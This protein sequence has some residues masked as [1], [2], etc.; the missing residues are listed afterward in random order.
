[1]NQLGGLSAEAEETTELLAC[2]ADMLEPAFRIITDDHSNRE[3]ESLAFDG[4]FKKVM[5]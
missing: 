2:Y 3:S 4:A 1:M 5:L